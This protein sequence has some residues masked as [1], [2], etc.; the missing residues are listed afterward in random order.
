MAELKIEYLP[1]EALKPYGK[2]ARKHGTE[3]VDAIAAS[4]E[5]FDFSDPIGVWGPDNEI[6]EGHG[7]VLAAKKQGIDRVPVIRLDHL[8]EDEAKA[9]RLAHNRTAELSAWDFDAQAAELAELSDFDMAAFGFDL[10]DTDEF[11]VDEDDYDGEPPEE[12]RT[13]RGDIWQLGRHRLMCGDA[14]SH[15]DVC[16]LMGGGHADVC[17]SSP[18]YNMGGIENDYSGAPD[19]G[20]M[21]AGKGYAEY[22]DALTDEEYSMMLINAARNALEYSDDVMLNIGVLAGTR[23]GIADLL[24]ELKENFFEIVTWEKKS[25]MPHGMPSQAGM[26]S[27]R[28][29]PIFCFNS[30]G[31]RSFKHPQFSAG[32][33]INLVKTENN[34]RN[35]YAAI[36]GAA[37]PVALPACIISQFVETSILDLFGGTGTTMIAAEQTGRKCYMM[38]LAPK[39][40]DVIIDRW[41]TLTGEKAKLLT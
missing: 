19:G 15:D 35:E 3:D 28:T 40:C 22:D 17:F 12:P 16:D 33:G 9:Y 29:E 14:T 4:I 8:T 2:N 31:K 34:S 23:R 7:R 13:K 36:H 39:Y 32:C 10:Q 11:D 1:I 24:Y 20:A 21:L 25:S 37:F 38:E 26:V 5:A 41:E 30:A 6:V 18:P 27:H